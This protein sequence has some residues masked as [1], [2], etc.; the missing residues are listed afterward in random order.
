[1]RARALRAVAS[2]DAL[3]VESAALI[4]A[5]GVALGTFPVYGFPTILCALAALILRLNIPALQ[6]VNQLSSPLQLALLVPF[7]RLGSRL[8][9]S[10]TVSP[11]PLAL[12]LAA[13]TLQAIAGWFCI[14]I[15]VGILLYWTLVCVL[16][17]RR[18]ECFDG[19]ENSG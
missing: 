5:V 11:A 12:Q 10:H 17:K 1:M 16:R 13:A 4:I 2:L 8:V 3:S 9:V 6:L 7:A 18:R 14:S 19:V 15:P